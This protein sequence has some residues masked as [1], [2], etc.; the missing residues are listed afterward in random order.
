MDGNWGGDNKDTFWMDDIDNDD[1]DGVKLI[2]IGSNI[3]GTSYDPG[4]GDDVR[5]VVVVSNRS[6]VSFPN[7]D[8]LLLFV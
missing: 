1:D 6:S 5:C 7:V 4:P 3:R 2:E 8:M